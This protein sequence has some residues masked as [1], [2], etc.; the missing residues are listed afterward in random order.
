VA[1]P[2]AVVDEAVADPGM[3]VRGTVTPGEAWTPGP[4]GP[5]GAGVI[6][7]SPW[8]CVGE[9][10]EATM[11]AGLLAGQ[12][13]PPISELVCLASA[14]SRHT[15]VPVGM[16]WREG[17]AVADLDALPE[18]LALRIVYLHVFADGSRAFADSIA[19]ALHI[20][21]WDVEIRSLPADHDLYRAEP[22]VYDVTDGNLRG[23]FAGERLAGVISASDLGSGWTAE[24]GAELTPAW[25]LG[26]NVIFFLLE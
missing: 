19:S 14:A 21:E 1:G 25:A 23:L 24:S 2:P 3:F 13:A 12:Q 17:I 4:P 18:G 5:E 6:A 15:Q 7:L 9:T 20:E 26:I 11:A 16:V 22:T 8:L 10:E